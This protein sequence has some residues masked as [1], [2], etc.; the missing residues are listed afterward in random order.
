M[1]TPLSALRGLKPIEL[2]I[3]VPMHGMA[4]QLSV[5][6]MAL[7]LGFSGD[8]S[9]EITLAVAELTSNLIKHAGK[10]TLAV[11]PVGAGERVGLEIEASD[12]GPG[13]GNIE[14]SFEDG[15]STAGSLGYGLGTVN[16]LMDEVD[17]HSAPDCGTQILCRRW[18]RCEQRGFARSLWEVGIL[19]RPHRGFRENGDAFVVKEWDDRLLVGLIDGLGH[20]ELAQ[21]AALAAQSYVRSHYDQPLDKI[22]A[23]AGRACLA[24][25]GVVMALAVFQASSQMAFASIG[26]VEVRAKSGSE[27]LPFVCKRGYLGGAETNVKVQQFSWRPEWMLVL[28]TDGLRSRWQWSDIPGIES[29]SAH[30]VAGRLMDTLATRQDD[31]TVLALRSRDSWR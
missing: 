5:R 3:S 27:R 12:R 15:Y 1:A 25:R 29:A 31:A 30:S 24:T 20:G 22:F 18:L 14:K 6:Q 4:A 23:G 13:I 28:H 9:E 17:I 11:R 2:I 16:R 26:N 7:S 8:A 10:G 19:T 21:K